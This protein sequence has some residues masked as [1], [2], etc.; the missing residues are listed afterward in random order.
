[1][2]RN[3]ETLKKFEVFLGNCF[4]IEVPCPI[5]GL[6]AH[7]ADG[8]SYRCEQCQRNTVFL[9]KFYQERDTGIWVHFQSRCKNGLKLSQK[10]ACNLCWEEYL[11]QGYGI[12]CSIC[13]LNKILRSLDNDE[14]DTMCDECNLE[15][16]IKTHPNYHPNGY[17]M[18]LKDSE[19][20]SDDE[21]STNTLDHTLR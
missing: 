3:F 21:S 11:E 5:L 18:P 15:E 8:T 20:Q 12:H 19:N 17:N 14:K 9:G 1:M 2:S 13:K 16:Y 7:F 10:T 4:F 6:I